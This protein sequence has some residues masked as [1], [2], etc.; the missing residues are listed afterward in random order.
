MSEALLVETEDE[1]LLRETAEEYLLRRAP[2]TH[3][4]PIEG[5][6]E[7]LVELG[8]D[9]IPAEFGLTETTIVMEELGRHLA[10]T[11][12]L[13]QVLGGSLVEGGLAERSEVYIA[14]GCV[15]AECDTEPVRRLDG[16]DCVRVEVHRLGQPVPNFQKR[17]DQARIAL[18]AEML[19]GMRTA[20]ALTLDY[21]KTRHQFGRPIGANQALQHRAVD[22]FVQLELC[23]SAVMAAARSPTP[24]LA[25]LA[26]AQCSE[27]F[28]H[29]AKEGIQL[30]GGI[31]MTEEA[32]I[33][34][35]LKRAAVCAQSM[36]T[37]SFH[38]RRWAEL[39]GY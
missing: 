10:H 4:G 35:Y 38:R 27:A 2:G 33:G 20:F 18:A 9:Q 17:L 13:H 8:W 32:D 6:W 1:V 21:L 25:S 28:L 5:L 30:H 36:G 3:R 19:G 22:C 11:P 14:A 12:M 15:V 39:N 7:D 34:L 31:G 24:E 37:A 26:K 23:R 29:V 16:R